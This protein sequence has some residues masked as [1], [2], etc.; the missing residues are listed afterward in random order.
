MKTQRNETSAPQE[1]TLVLNAAEGRLQVAAG[2]ACADGTQQ[3]GLLFSFEMTVPRQGTEILAPAIQDAMKRMRVSMQQIGRIAVVN[4]PGGFT[5][6]RLALSTALGMARALNVPCAGVSYT[7]ALA[8]DAAAVLHAADCG[9]PLLWA[10]L[11][12]RRDQVMVQGFR[13]DNTGTA[14]PLHPVTTFG[15]ADACSHMAAVTQSCGCKAC[16]FGSGV[17]RNAEAICRH[18]TAAGISHSLLPARFSHVRPEALLAATADAVWSHEPVEPE[19][20]RGC[21]AE[22]NLPRMAAARGMQ[23]EKAVEALHRLTTS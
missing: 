14:V 3:A 12:A 15:V 13:P 6:L 20:V 7:A 22:E 11:H 5:G 23:P 18:L 21:D 17:Q 4:G 16:L 1:I 19:Y 2:N 8:A 10:V 9:S